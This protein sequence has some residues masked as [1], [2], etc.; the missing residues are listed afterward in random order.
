MPSDT[1]ELALISWAFVHGLVILAREGA[2]EAAASPQAI[3]AAELTHTL[4]ELFTQYVSD[5]LAGAK[6]NRVT[7]KQLT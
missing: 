3:N 7:G 2:L 6:T 1:P 4:T 5:D